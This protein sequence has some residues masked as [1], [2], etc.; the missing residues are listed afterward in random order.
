VRNQ[1]K[2]VRIGIKRRELVH[3][4]LRGLGHW[5]HVE[6][7]HCIWEGKLLGTEVWAEGAGTGFRRPKILSRWR[8]SAL[9]L[10]V[11]PLL[12]VWNDKSEQWNGTSPLK[13]DSVPILLV[14]W[15]SVLLEKKSIEECQEIVVN[16]HAFHSRWPKN[17]VH[18][19]YSIL[20]MLR[21]FYLKPI[22]QGLT[23]IQGSMGL[24]QG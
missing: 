6:G 15:P 14:Y 4:Y 3:R 22:R 20:G 21:V 10:L 19:L 18:L 23:E 13:V 16:V 11:C 24:G 8:L 5:V 2:D 9:W 1:D 12:S 7:I 17:P